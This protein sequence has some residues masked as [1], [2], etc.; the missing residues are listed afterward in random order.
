VLRMS[1]IAH[2]RVFWGVWIV[3][4][5]S[6]EASPSDGTSYLLLGR[7]NPGCSVFGYT[8]VIRLSVSRKGKR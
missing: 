1:E 8:L 5:V 4:S 6:V 7:A 3:A 2:F